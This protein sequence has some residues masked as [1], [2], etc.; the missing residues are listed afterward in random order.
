MRD[1]YKGLQLGLY[2]W[3]MFKP[4]E[5]I[6]RYTGESLGVFDAGDDDGI[7]HALTRLPP[8]RHDKVLKVPK[9]DE[10]VELIDARL[11]V[12]QP[13]G[14]GGAR[15]QRHG[16]DDRR[17]GGGSGGNHS[18][19]YLVRKPYAAAA[20]RDIMQTVLIHNTQ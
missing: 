15:H 5:E 9:G 20:G 19:G 18:D 10:K 13:L 11:R 2:E 4:G 3:R 14:S 7:A 12:R 6:G 17:H 1:D 16:G 8:G